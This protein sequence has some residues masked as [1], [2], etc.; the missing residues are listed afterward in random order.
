MVFSELESGYIMFLLWLALMLAPTSAP[1]RPATPSGLGEGFW[2]ARGSQLL[3]SANH[4]VRIAGINWYGFET[5]QAVPGGLDVQDYKAILQT[6]KRNGYNAIRI[7]FSSQMIESPIV[8]GIKFSNAAGPINT[9]LRGLNS[10]QILDKIIA[11]ARAQGLKVILDNHRSEAGAGPEANGL[12][13]TQTYSEAS[14]IE[15]WQMLARRYAADSTVLGFDL[16]NEPHNAAAGG[17]CWGCGSTNDWQ[18]AAERAGNAVLTINPRLLIFV[19]GI[20]AYE[21]DFY[22]WGGNL[23]G[24]RSAPVRLSAPH[25]LVYSAHDYGPAEAPQKWFTTDMSDATLNAVWTK[26]WAYIAQEDIA[27][28]WLGEFGVEIAAPSL[29]KAASAPPANPNQALEDIWFQ[30]MTA[31]LAH[32]PRISWTYWTLNATDCYG[33]LNPNYDAPRSAFRQQALAA[34]QLPLAIRPHSVMVTPEKSKASKQSVAAPA[35][36]TQPPPPQAPI[37]TTTQPISQS[38]NVA[39]QPMAA[40]PASTQPASLQCRVTYTNVNDWHTGFSSNIVLHNSSAAPI[41]HWTLTFTFSGAQKISQLW[42]GRL[43]Q[44]GRE[45][46]IT[47]EAWNATVPPN[48]DLPPIGFNASYEGTNQPPA[49]FYLNG[50]LCQ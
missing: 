8:P 48:S 16:R 36:T 9:D 41:T 34:I 23:M 26:H 37:L 35:S 32:D 40:A 21:N 11:A 30:S 15:D 7:P 38:Q 12:W 27:P 22:W 47:N 19:E 3:D 50:T 13:Y 17:A 14:W 33:L 49:K 43:D 4:P 1:A 25:Q 6:I 31:F 45:V 42:N 39:P 44:Q 28:V 2:H 5:V 46:N 18:L 24:V 20:D 29:P 10:L